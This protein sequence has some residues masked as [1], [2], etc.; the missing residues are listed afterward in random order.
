MTRNLLAKLSLV[1]LISICAVS[2]VNAGMTS[3]TTLPTY[4]Q[5][6][7][8]RRNQ[9]PYT[10]STQSKLINKID[11]YSAINK[12]PIAG[13]VTEKGLKTMEYIADRQRE[14][15]HGTGTPNAGVIRDKTNETESPYIR[16]AKELKKE[17]YH[18]FH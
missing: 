1:S 3:S 8:E 16:D 10:P 13:P 9:K 7:Q 15:N 6:E 17:V 14:I 4:T 12:V 11:P 5:R 2:F 18:F